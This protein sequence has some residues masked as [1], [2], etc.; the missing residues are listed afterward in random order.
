M[1][2][3]DSKR[4]PRSTGKWLGLFAAAVGIVIIALGATSALRNRKPEVEVAVALPPSDKPVATTLLNASGYVTPRRRATVAAK[5]TGK[6]TRVYVDEG[7]R[8]TQGQVLA[9]LDDSDYQVA[10]ASDKAD[11]D[12]TAALMNDLEVQL[13]NADRELHRSTQLSDAGIQTP[14]ALDAAQTLVNRMKAQIAQTQ[15]QV[16]AAESK[17]SD[18]QSRTLRTASCVR[19]LMESRFRKTRS[20][21]KW[22][23]RSPQAEVYAHGYFHDC[24][25]EF[26]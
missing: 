5:I 15:E 4:K 3:D 20:R 10:L 23:R 25:Y 13:G 14:E 22:C 6:V 16:K 21:A 24:G 8:V 17:M 26:E 18:R 11:R 7:M 19:L 2:I 12:A 1:R 9:T